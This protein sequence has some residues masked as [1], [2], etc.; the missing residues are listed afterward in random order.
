MLVTVYTSMLT[1]KILVRGWF[2]QRI[3]VD[4]MPI[5]TTKRMR[6]KVFLVPLCRN[7][8]LFLFLS[9]QKGAAA[10]LLRACGFPPLQLW[11]SSWHTEHVKKEIGCA[12]SHF[13]SD[14]LKSES[15]KDWAWRFPLHK[16]NPR[17]PEYMSFLLNMH[18]HRAFVS[19][20]W[21]RFHSS[22]DCGTCMYP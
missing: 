16:V 10:V 11:I 8:L 18:V 15:E 22:W 5:S 1:G 19:R 2:S 13:S 21:Y 3:I 9:L 17:I 14:I 4:N 7:F 12:F 6:S 20:S